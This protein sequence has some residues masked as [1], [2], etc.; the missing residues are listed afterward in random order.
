MRSMAGL[1]ALGL[2]LLEATVFV[3]R[4]RQRSVQHVDAPRS[5]PSA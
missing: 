2:G 1:G 3:E 4:P 5:S